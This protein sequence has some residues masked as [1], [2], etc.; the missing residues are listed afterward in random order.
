MP[1]CLYGILAISFNDACHH[2]L[3]ANGDARVF[4]RPKLAPEILRLSIISLCIAPEE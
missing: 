1:S 2:L 3:N 4:E